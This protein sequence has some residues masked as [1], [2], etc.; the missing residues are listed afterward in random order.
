MKQ[1]LN[2]LQIQSVDLTEMA[3]NGKLDPIIGR[4]EGRR[5]CQVLDPHTHVVL[6]EIRRTIQSTFSPGDP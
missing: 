1:R 4:D 5:V 6:A 3:R 2:G